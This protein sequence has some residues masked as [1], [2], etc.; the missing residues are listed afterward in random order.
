[1]KRIMKLLLLYQKLQRLTQGSM[2]I[3]DYYKEMENA[4]MRTNMEEDREA[5]MTKFFSGLNDEITNI[6]ELHHY[7]ELADMV[8][9][10]MKI[11]KQ[12]KE[13]GGAKT[14]QER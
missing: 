12:L 7:V 13:K 3:E 8:S 14:F 11:E 2:F 1:M 6:I 5:T 4:M 9:M 10:A